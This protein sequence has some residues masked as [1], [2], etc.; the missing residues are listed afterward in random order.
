MIKT[1]NNS[2]IIKEYK[3]HIF[4]IA[5]SMLFLSFIFSSYIIDLS[6]LALFFYI[7]Y[8][9]RNEDRPTLIDNENA[10]ISPVDGEVI[11]IEH[12][13]YKKELNSSCNKITIKTKFYQIG[14]FK[15]PFSGEIIKLKK[16]SGLNIR[17]QHPL[18][19]CL[20][21]KLIK[22]S[23]EIFIKHTSYLGRI[24]SYIKKNM[25]IQS[26][27]IYGMYLSG[28]TEIYIKDN[29]RIA[30]NTK[31]KVKTQETLLGYFIKEDKNAK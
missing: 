18:N 30:I 10:I 5:I 8:G 22:K 26:N 4:I 9:L 2:Y 21:L 27:E 25:K 12:L 29:I 24:Y 23:S 19:E 7:I 14:L 17:P 3:I 1:L 20:E 31:T 6:L 13:P 15:A 16:I 11:K 28:L